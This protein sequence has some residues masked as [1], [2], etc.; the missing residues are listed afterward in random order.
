VGLLVD[1]TT[2]RFLLFFFFSFLSPLF[3]LLLF[4][5]PFSSFLFYF[6]LVRIYGIIPETSNVAKLGSLYTPGEDELAGADR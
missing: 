5:F 6:P 1:W 4:S 3:F 2:A